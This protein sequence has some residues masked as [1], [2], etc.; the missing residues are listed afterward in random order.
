[1]N[2]TLNINNKVKTN[3][4]KTGTI[5]KIFPMGLYDT[6]TVYMVQYDNSRNKGMFKES[7]VTLIPDDNSSYENMTIR[8]FYDRYKKQH[9]VFLIL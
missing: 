9:E 3:T 7:E 1:M 6:E 5:E 8:E 2:K 4:G